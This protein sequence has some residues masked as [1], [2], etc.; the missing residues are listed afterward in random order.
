MNRYFYG[1]TFAFVLSG[2]V[3]A[4]VTDEP[5]TPGL[6]LLVSERQLVRASF[7]RLGLEQFGAIATDQLSLSNAG[8]PYPMYISDGGDGKFGAGDWIEYVAHPVA[9]ENSYYSEYA[10]YNVYKLGF[11]GERE[12]E[13]NPMIGEIVE[14]PG[15][16]GTI[17]RRFEEDSL[18]VRF[19][20]RGNQPAAEVWYWQRISPIE[21][22]DIALDLPNASNDRPELAIRI[23]LRGWSQQPRTKDAPV[24]HAVELYLND[25]KIGATE[26]DGQ[27]ES[28]LSV[29]EISP[30]LIRDGSNALSL[31]VPE[32]E[33]EDGFLIDVSLVNWIE[34]EYR[35]DGTVSEELFTLL[36]TGETVGLLPSVGQK[37]IA[38]TDTGARFEVDGGGKPVTLQL[39]ANTREVYVAS[40]SAI[41]MPESVRADTASN[42]RETA[43]QA[44][45]L[46]IAHESL[47]EAAT[48]LA[49]FRREQGL[50]VALINVQDIYDEFGHG[51]TSPTA[52]RDFIAHAYRHWRKPAARFVLLIGD[53]NW[54][55]H[56]EEL[57]DRNYADWT[58]RGRSELRRFGKNS[59]TAYDDLTRLRNLIPAWQTT[60]Y[61]GY[62]ASDNGYVAVD[63][64]DWLPDL[65]I[66]RFPVSSPMEVQAIV[67]KTIDYERN[68]E[69]GPWRRNLLWVTNEQRRFQR[70]SDELADGLGTE[71][72]AGGRV[73]PSK[74]EAD[75]AL[76]QGRLVDAFNEGQLMVH[77]MGHG[78]RYIWRTGP[79]DPKKNHDL[80]S[81]DHLDQLQPTARLPLVLS[82]TCY[83][84]PFDH[85]TAD[86]LGEKFLRMPQRGAIGVFAASW[87][88]APTKAFSETLTRELTRT[89][90]SVGEA[91]ML[92]KQQAHSR[93]MVETYNYLGDPAT[94]LALPSGRMQ[95]RGQREADRSSVYSVFDDETPLIEGQAIIEWLDED[96][97]VLREESVSF[98]N[99]Q[100]KVEASE[101][102]SDA[103]P[104]QVRV[105]AWNAEAGR[106]AVGSAQLASQ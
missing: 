97:T 29:S 73:Y 64:D 40:E 45:Y 70:I 102:S 78:G 31:R 93:I 10:R 106:D 34:A 1:F 48:P 95:L 26:W 80:F 30:E 4:G 94:R 61:E 65:A 84:A 5:S 17:S 101:W 9:G 49:D 32:R 43:Q 98:A 7:D 37:I 87:R 62:A 83:T 96:E 81:L 57:V 14:A 18:R 15:E 56:N 25:R 19:S 104:T 76:H 41:R 35:H 24:D 74:N 50:S 33:H 71:G 103:F 91:I 8:E 28:I 63:G 69:V 39:P 92:A 53:A 100:L 75:N 3:A 86:S 47:L 54:D 16:M 55:V 88:N 23:S 82:M 11:S 52:I 79:P 59:S 68:S 22:F 12:A 6:D 67:Q 20:Q 60:T 46:M 90:T 36:P 21:P 58:F 85:P 66:G 72:F 44:D 51:I 38:H 13:S 27:T 99:A 2:A 42:L 77:F 105:Y 89:E